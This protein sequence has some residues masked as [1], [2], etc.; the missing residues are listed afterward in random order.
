MFSVV[1]SCRMSK[2]SVEEYLKTLMARLK[3]AG[4]GEDLTCCLPC[5]LPA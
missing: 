4:E 1:E 3:K 2:R 5:H